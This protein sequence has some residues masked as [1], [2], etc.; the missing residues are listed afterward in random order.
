[1]SNVLEVV[2]FILAA[3]LML[4]GLFDILTGI[5]GTFRFRYAVNRMH[6]A[7]T[8]DSLGTLSLV[9]GVLV[10]VG[11]NASFTLKLIL[12]VAFLWLTSPLC[13]HMAARLELWTNDE[14]E[15]HMTVEETP[16]GVCGV[17]ERKEENK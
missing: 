2:R 5:A 10:A 3:V 9:L 12:L 7:A 4:F 16:D 15:A 11:W 13:S 14:P 8:V 1:M 6:T 17:P